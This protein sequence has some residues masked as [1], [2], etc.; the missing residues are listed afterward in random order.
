MKRIS[1]IIS[2]ISLAV[3]S[4]NAQYH[5]KY[6]RAYL[7]GYRYQPRHSYQDRF[8]ARWNHPYVGL[9]IGPSFT[10]VHSDDPYLDGSNMKAGLNVGI[11]TGFPLSSYVPLYL[12][13]GLYYTEKGGRGTVGGSHFKYNL[14]YLELPFVFK[15]KVN[16]SRSF[17]LQ[18]Y[19][20]GY[21]G[22]GVAGRIKDFQEREAYSSFGNSDYSFRRG[23]AGIRLGCGIGYDML[24]AE[25]NY[26][27]GLANISHNSFD[28]CRNGALTLT[29]GVNF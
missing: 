8:Y 15:Y 28:D 25:I 21:V 20:G 10:T 13:T 19:L 17:S 7:E 9:R 23:D 18:P 12:E 11:A 26:D 16:M 27:W 5:G 3:M 29:V 6:P 22:L 24:Y 1:L 14:D 2:L 4:A